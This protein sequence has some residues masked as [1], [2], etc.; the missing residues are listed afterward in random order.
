MGPSSAPGPGRGRA[1]GP[2]GGGAGWGMADTQ[3]LVVSRDGAVATLWLNRPEKRNA[4]TFEMWQGIADLCGQLAADDTVRVLIVRGT[5]DH[6]CA[7]ADITE[8]GQPDGETYHATNKA[9][10]DALA[11]F[12]KPTIALIT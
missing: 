6:F 2:C 7:G 10:D 1:E 9:A 8:L 5:G 11:G 3:E 12:P 4:V